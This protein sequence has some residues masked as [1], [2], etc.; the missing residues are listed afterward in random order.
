MLHAYRLRSEY[1]GL[2]PDTTI[3]LYDGSD[4]V[5]GKAFQEAKDG[6]VVLDDED[7]EQRLQMYALEEY[8]AVKSTTV[9][10]KARKQAEADAKARAEAEAKAQQQS[11]SG[12]EG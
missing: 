1:E 12:Q 11:S 5:V 9:P 8:F 3:S 2:D 4:Y 6:V 7:P 10:D